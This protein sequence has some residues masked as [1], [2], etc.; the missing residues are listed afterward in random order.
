MCAESLIPLQTLSSEAAQSSNA[1]I[2]PNRRGRLVHAD[3]LVLMRQLPTASCDLIYIDPPFRSQRRRTSSRSANGFDD[4][5]EGDL[6]GFVD[7][8][9]VRLREMHRLLSD[10][11]SLYVHLDWRTVHYVKVALDEIFGPDNFLNEIIW[12]YRTGGLSKHWFGRKHDTILLYARNRG[13]H[14][15][16]VRREGEFRTDGLLFDDDGKPFKNTKK[17]RLY[18]HPDGPAMTDVWDIPFLSTVSSERTGYP[19]QKPMALLERIVRTSSN[20]GDLVADFFCGSGTTAVVADRLE[21]RWLA[22]D[23]GDEAVRLAAKR[24]RETPEKIA[25]PTRQ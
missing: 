7:F 19:S 12:H 22:C 15:F 23:I 14:T 16:N 5:W 1:A 21:R 6:P 3:N 13:R 4:R 8:L 2:D 11:G 25:P 18:F 17:G 24:L 9:A 20:P 10:R